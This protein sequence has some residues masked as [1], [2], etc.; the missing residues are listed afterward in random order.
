M[1]EKNDEGDYNA[2]RNRRY[3]ILPQPWAPLSYSVCVCANVCM[4]FII[5]FRITSIV[6][7]YNYRHLGWQK[8]K[9]K[10]NLK[11]TFSCN[12]V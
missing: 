9:E 6:Y 10:K 3:W 5:F 7:L 2:G 11:H 12:L 8:V 1:Y 4:L